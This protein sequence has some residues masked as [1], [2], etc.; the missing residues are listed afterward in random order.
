MMAERKRKQGDNAVGADTAM[1]W[2]LD[3]VPNPL[4]VGEPA[5]P[6]EEEVMKDA[7]G[8]TIEL[9][10][11]EDETQTSSSNFEDSKPLARPS[12]PVSA[13]ATGV[14]TKG[15]AGRLP[16][17][18]YLTCDDDN[19]SE[20]QCLLRKQIELFEATENDIYANAQGRNKPI[21]LGQVGI[22][23]KHCSQWPNRGRGAV[24]YPSSLDG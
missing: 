15:L 3:P 6:I 22:R 5:H 23:C 21:V 14:K 17:T 1:G 13:F 16:I 8:L 7:S 9:S 19:L 18:L 10:S 24:F 4:A 2:M 12:Q 20:H 11:E